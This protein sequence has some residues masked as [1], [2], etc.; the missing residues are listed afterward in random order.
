MFLYKDY[1][2][3]ITEI[4]SYFAKNFMVFTLTLKYETRKST[5]LI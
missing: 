2:A 1:D 3:L 5:I 4:Y